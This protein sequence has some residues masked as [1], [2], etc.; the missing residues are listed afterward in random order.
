MWSWLTSCAAQYAYVITLS[1]HSEI[2]DRLITAKVI[3]IKHTL[4]VRSPSAV[5][6]SLPAFAVRIFG[7][8]TPET[9]QLNIR[10][11]N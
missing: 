11:R 7:A 2:V 4:T 10:N 3:I 6:I 9:P 8:Q 1:V 5:L